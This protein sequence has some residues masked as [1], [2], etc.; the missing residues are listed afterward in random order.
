LI[1][2]AVGSLD[3]TSQFASVNAD[4]SQI[5]LT[6]RSDSGHKETTYYF[7]LHYWIIDYQTTN[8]TNSFEVIVK[9]LQDSSTTIEEMIYLPTTN[10]PP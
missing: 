3:D 8:K 4:F 2:V 7:D 9:G 1:S 5:R 6:P 10:E